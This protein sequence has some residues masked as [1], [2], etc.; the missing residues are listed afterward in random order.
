MH[1]IA[2]LTG[3]CLKYGLEIRL[4]SRGKYRSLKD[5]SLKYGC[6][7]AGGRQQVTSLSHTCSVVGK[8]R[9]QESGRGGGA[10]RSSLQVCQGQRASGARHGN[11]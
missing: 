1:T 7:T 2:R 10:V 5:I 3:L 4:L 8:E 9:L 6:N 11:I